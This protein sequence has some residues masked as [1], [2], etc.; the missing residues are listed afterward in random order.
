MTARRTVQATKLRDTSQM[1]WE[2]APECNLQLATTHHDCNHSSRGIPDAMDSTVIGTLKSRNCAR[3]G[4]QPPAFT[5]ASIV[6]ALATE[7]GGVKLPAMLLNQA[8]AIHA[9]SCSTL[10]GR[11]DSKAALLKRSTVGTFPAMFERIT[12]V[13]HVT[14][15]PRGSESTAKSATTFQASAGNPVFVKAGTTTNMAAKKMRTSMSM[16]ANVVLASRPSAAS[17]STAALNAVKDVLSSPNA[18]QLTILAT[19][20]S[21]T[22]TQAVRRLLSVS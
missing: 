21:T 7:P 3:V 11:S 12:T 18:M 1:T 19:T 6:I 2:P 5:A 14:M 10:S 22:R 15:T 17:K 4:A 13:T 9:V 20:A 8:S 16:F